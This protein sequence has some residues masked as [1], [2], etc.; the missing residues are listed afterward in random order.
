MSTG[1]DCEFV[2]KDPGQWFYRLQAWPYGDWPIY[3]EYGPF[4]T[5]AE[6]HSHLC[7]HHANPGGFTLRA[8][9]GCPHDLLQ[10]K[11]D[12]SQGCSRC[13]ARVKGGDTL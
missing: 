12:G 10:N 9:P 5:F 2:E 11:R 7:D 4:G 6:A 8:Q 3:D 13:G 1:A